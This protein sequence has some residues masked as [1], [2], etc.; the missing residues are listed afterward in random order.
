MK[1]NN[2]EDDKKH[3]FVKKDKK[4]KFVRK[5]LMKLPKTVK[6]SNIKFN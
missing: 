2:L 6:W 4:K 5:D 1:L 3:L